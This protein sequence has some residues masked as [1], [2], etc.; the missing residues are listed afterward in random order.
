[1]EGGSPAVVAA[2]VVTPLD[3][4]TARAGQAVTVI[5]APGTLGVVPLSVVPADVLTPSSGSGPGL[6]G[7]YYAS[8]DQ[9]GSPGDSFVSSTLDANSI[10]P[11]G[12][13]SARWTGTLTPGATGTYRFSLEDAGIA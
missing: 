3:A 9:S 13:F 6:F 7:E 1:M 2:P 8:M 4:I 10:L 5:Y 11:S 12:S